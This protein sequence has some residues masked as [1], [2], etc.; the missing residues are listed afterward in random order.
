MS[1]T[2]SK[3]MMMKR[4]MMVLVLAGMTTAGLRAEFQEIDLTIFGMD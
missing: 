1:A 4:S 3:E 2:S